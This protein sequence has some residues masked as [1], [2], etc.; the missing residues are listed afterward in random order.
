MP[1]AL[2][3]GANR[4]L[5][6]EFCRQYLAAGWTVHAACR[7]PGR[8]TELAALSRDSWLSIHRLDVAHR[9]DIIAL[10]A[11]LDQTPIDLL[12]NNAGIYGDD[13]EHEFGHLDADRWSEVFRINTQGPVLMTEAF[14]PHLLAGQ[15]RLSVAISSLM[16]SIADNRSGGAL[17]YRSSKA[18]LNAV[19]HS[20]AIDLRQR[21][22][23]VLILHPG[24]VQTDMGGPR[25]PTTVVDSVSGMRRVIDGFSLGDSGQFADFRGQVLPW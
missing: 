10:A 8:A 9:A 23:G 4:G 19:M 5:G 13:R 12:I 20:L 16:G 2:I 21:G 3:S 22:I 25:A 11:E 1:T 7:Q 14:L 24:W 18:A 15:R 17:L 6:L